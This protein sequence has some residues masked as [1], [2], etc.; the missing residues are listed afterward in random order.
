[1]VNIFHWY[2]EVLKINSDPKTAALRDSS[3]KA[4]KKKKWKTQNNLSF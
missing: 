1:M 4:K 3:T 2:K